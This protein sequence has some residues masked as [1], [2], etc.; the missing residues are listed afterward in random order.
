MSRVIQIFPVYIYSKTWLKQPLKIDK[1]K[2]FK[3]NGSL[4][5]VFG[6]FCNTFDLHKQ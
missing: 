5:K 6:A 3:I 4:M 2:V 1:T